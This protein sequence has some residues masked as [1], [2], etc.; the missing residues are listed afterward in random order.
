MK[1]DFPARIVNLPKIEDDRGNLSFVEELTH[2]PFCIK[3]S[4]WIYDVPGGGDRDGHAFKTNDEFIIALSG[5]F[6]VV[7]DDGKEK[8]HFYLNRSYFGLYV[9]HGLWREIRDFSTNSLA[10]VLS[11][12]SYDEADYVRDYEAFKQLKSDERL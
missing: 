12:E 1:K 8:R 5:S 7:L 11:S 9:P 4:Y 2:I 6:D 10:L 3:R